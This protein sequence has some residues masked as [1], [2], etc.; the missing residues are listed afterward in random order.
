MN[1]GHIKRL[2]SKGVLC[3]FIW[4]FP[5]KGVLHDIKTKAGDWSDYHSWKQWPTIFEE[6]MYQNAAKQLLF[7]VFNFR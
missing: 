4:I 7:L 5:L 1:E 3:S 2:K 6:K